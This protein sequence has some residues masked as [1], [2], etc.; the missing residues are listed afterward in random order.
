[1]MLVTQVE[2]STSKLQGVLCP[3]NGKFYDGIYFKDS[4]RSNFVGYL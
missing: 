3:P 2:R 4:N 1:M